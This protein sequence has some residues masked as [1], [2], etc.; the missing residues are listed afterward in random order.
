MDSPDNEPIEWTEEAKQTLT[1]APEFI[2]EM[3]REMIEQFARDEGAKRITA[4]LMKRAR[5]KF[6]M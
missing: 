2:R 5:A 1:Q 6:G 3:A 4:E